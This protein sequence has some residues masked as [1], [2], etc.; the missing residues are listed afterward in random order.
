M[1]NNTPVVMSDFVVTSLGLSNEVKRN[2]GARP[3]D[4]DFSPRDIAMT[5]ATKHRKG[6]QIVCLRD[7]S[8]SAAGALVFGIDS[9]LDG[10]SASAPV[11][12]RYRL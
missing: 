2:D 3:Y 12:A 4:K 10:H 5:R 7:L 8:A 11:R 6:R 9:A 1:G